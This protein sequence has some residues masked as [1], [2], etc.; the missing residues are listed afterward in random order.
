VNVNTATAREMEDVLDISKVD[1]EAIVAFR[2][3]RGEFQTLDALTGVP[4]VDSEVLE[5][6]KERITFK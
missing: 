2:G 4:G 6:R 1:A 3:Q 5:K